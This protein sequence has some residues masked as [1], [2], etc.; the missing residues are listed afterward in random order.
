MTGTNTT[1]SITPNTVSSATAIIDMMTAI[2][3][4]FAT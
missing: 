3:T 4:A 2:M 1:T